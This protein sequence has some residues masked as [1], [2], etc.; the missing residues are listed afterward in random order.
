MNSS[1]FNLGV[2]STL[3]IQSVPDDY[4]T[5]IFITAGKNCHIKILGIK[6]LNSTLSIHLGD[7]AE[8]IIGPN[9]LM[10]GTINISAHEKSKIII[11]EG[12]L[13]STTDIWSSDMHKIIDLDSNER[14]NH[15]QDITIGKHVW[16]GYQ[17]L[18]LKG[19]LIFD[20]CILGARSVIT[21]STAC[22]PNCTIAG[23][24]AKIVKCNVTWQA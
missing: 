9:Q 6:I 18:I 12:C 11:G 5:K 15:A 1:N 4:M 24:P 17:V 2:D 10:N 22:K 7:D 13:W 3:Q 19:S 16:F 20:G 23:S 21:K 8:L 14:I